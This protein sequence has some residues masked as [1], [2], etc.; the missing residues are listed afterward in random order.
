M[1]D[2]LKLWSIALCVVVVIFIIGGADGLPRALDL[3]WIAMVIAAIYGSW[4]ATDRWW[5][6]RRDD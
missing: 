5:K 2:K 1:K 6:D 3:A 4:K